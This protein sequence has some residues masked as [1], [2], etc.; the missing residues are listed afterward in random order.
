MTKLLSLILC[1]AGTTWITLVLASL[2]R[3]RAWTMP[4]MK[5]AFGNRDNLPAPTPLAGRAMRTA[6]NTVEA[7]VLF[8]AIALVAH[9]AGMESAR[10]TFGAEIFF[11]SRLVYIPVYYAGITVLRT[12]VWGA[13]M[14]GL[15]MMLAA[16]S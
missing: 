3:A 9:A 7:F 5:L 10:V 13:G 8:T 6:T 2:I 4:G 12:L 11:W 16:M 1:M 15:G 14:V